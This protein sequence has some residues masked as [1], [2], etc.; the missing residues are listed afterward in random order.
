MLEITYFKWNKIISW[1]KNDLEGVAGTLTGRPTPAPSSRDPMG[2]N[3]VVLPLI[4]R[5]ATRRRYA[6]LLNM[7]SVTSAKKN[8][9]PTWGRTHDLP[10]VSRELG[11]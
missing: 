8:I 11:H 4:S 3:R 9:D 7:I 1:T 10:K 2:L 6:P 5:A